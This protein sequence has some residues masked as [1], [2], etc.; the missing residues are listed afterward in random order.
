MKKIILFLNGILTVSL[1]S[2]G[3]TGTTLIHTPQGFALLQNL[4]VGDQ[5]ICVANNSCFVKPIYSVQ[6]K[7]VENL[8]KVIT[9]GGDVI[10]SSPDA[11]FFLPKNQQWGHASELCAGNWL[12]Q[13]NGEGIKVKQVESLAGSTDIFDIGVTQYPN[14]GVAENGII[15]HNMSSLPAGLALIRGLCSYLNFVAVPAQHEQALDAFWE[16]FK[17]KYH[18]VEDTKELSGNTSM[19]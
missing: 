2:A 5:V 14:F 1:A 8:F 3:F 4:K 6:S 16:D 13:Q 17:K 15:V 10:C 9:H 12:L 7:K 19:A 18:L 11:R